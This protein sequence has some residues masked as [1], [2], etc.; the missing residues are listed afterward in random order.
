MNRRQFLL[1]SLPAVTQAQQPRVRV[2]AHLWLFAAKEPNYDAT[3]VLEEVFRQMSGAKLDGIELMHRVL[4][5]EGSVARIKSLSAQYRLPVTGTSWSGDLWNPVRH[6][7]E[8]A[9]MEVVLDR[10][11]M[12]GGRTLGVSVGDAR[13]KKTAVD[14]D[15]QADALRHILRLCAS[16]QIVPN[17]HNHVYEVRDGEHD[18]N[19]TLSRIPEIRL[20]PDLGWLY[21]AGI[22]PVDF[23]RRRG[24]QMVFAHLRNEKADHTWPEDLTDG[25]IDYAAVGKALREVGFQGDLMIELA[26]EKEFV[27]TRPYGESIR[28]SREWVRRVM[29]Y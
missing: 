4:L 27:A 22:D 8:L 17:L 16:R 23:I 13:R 26:H 6:A 15:A 25:A 24:R 28:L 10:L 12:L 5:A 2:G 11:Q 1:S 3:P 20:G 29:D 21:R 7:V 14:F 18:L 9:Q 19:G